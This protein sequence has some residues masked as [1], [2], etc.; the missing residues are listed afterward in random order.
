MNV[1]IMH[2]SH[3]VFDYTMPIEFRR[4]WIFFRQPELATDIYFIQFN[5]QMWLLILV[6]VIALQAVMSAV[7][8]YNISVRK[9]S[10]HREFGYKDMLSWSL[11]KNICPLPQY[12]F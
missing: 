12:P 5:H 7:S 6:T 4:F 9:R 3:Q 1:A 2:F 11:C 8:W 10:S